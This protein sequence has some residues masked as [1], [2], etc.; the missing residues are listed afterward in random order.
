MNKKWIMKL[1]ALMFV[2]MLVTACG[3]TNDMDPMDD[4]APQNEQDD[5]RDNDNLGPDDSQDNNNSDRNNNEMDGNDM[6]NNDQKGKENSN[7]NDNLNE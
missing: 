7:P 4:P 3:T 6:N 1:S 2:F 5:N